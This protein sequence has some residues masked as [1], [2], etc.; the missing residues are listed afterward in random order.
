MMGR[1][2][3]VDVLVREQDEAVPFRQD[4]VVGL[5]DPHSHLG[6]APSAAKSWLF[7]LYL[8]PWLVYGYGYGSQSR[9]CCPQSDLPPAAAHYTARCA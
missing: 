7:Y 5:P 3:V 9:C 6:L 8:R 2:R 4:N 1:V